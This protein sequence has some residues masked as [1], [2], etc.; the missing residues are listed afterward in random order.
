MEIRS[1]VIING[2]SF[3]QWQVELV[4]SIVG[5][6]EGVLQDKVGR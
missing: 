3:L 2:A 4:T 5:G 1:P 6:W